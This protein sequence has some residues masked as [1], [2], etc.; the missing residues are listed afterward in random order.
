MQPTE[1]TQANY[2][3]KSKNTRRKKKSLPPQPPRCKTS[4]AVKVKRT[5]PSPT[6]PASPKYKLKRSNAVLDL[7]ST[8]TTHPEMKQTAAPL[9][10]GASVET[11]SKKSRRKGSKRDKKSLKLTIPADIVP[12]EEPQFTILHIPDVEQAQ[13]EC[14][15][16]DIKTEVVENVSKAVCN[17]KESNA[18]KCGNECV[19]K[20]DTSRLLNQHK[21]CL[22]AKSL[23]QLFS[24]MNE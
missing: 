9:P 6:P 14:R 5:S 7:T 3:E 20:W 13:R 2:Q 10:P 18:D 19:A 12:K 4:P 24:N 22:F 1:T 16:V 23:F 21:N 15:Q 11:S 8:S 17:M